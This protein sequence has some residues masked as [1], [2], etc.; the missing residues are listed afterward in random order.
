MEKIVDHRVTLAPR[1]EPCAIG[2]EI[3]KCANDVQ[4]ASSF[5]PHLKSSDQVRFD[6][7]GVHRAR[8]MSRGREC[9]CPVPAS[10]LDDTASTA[11]FP[12]D[13]PNH[14]FGIKET[15][16]VLLVGHPAFTALHNPVP[17]ISSNTTLWYTPSRGKSSLDIA[18]SFNP[19][20]MI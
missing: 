3:S 17:F 4:N 20:L 10:E 14:A 7:K 9:E 11:F 15:V 16:P 13:C 8:C 5:G 12:E 19:K 18:V 2:Q 6:I 1:R